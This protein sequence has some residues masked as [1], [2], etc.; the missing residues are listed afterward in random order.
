AHPDRLRSRG[1]PAPA[2]FLPGPSLALPG[3]HRGARAR[4]ARGRRPA[5]LPAAV[6]RGGRR[7]RRGGTGA[8]KSAVILGCDGQDGRLLSAHLKGKGYRTLGI[9]RGTARADGIDWSRPVDITRAD[10]VE[11]LVSTVRPDAI[12][13]LA[14]IHHSSEEAPAE[15]LASM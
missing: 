4:L 15:D 6:H 10:E 1:P 8:M 11:A 14:A 13:H 3:R 12:C 5:G 9:G 7:F 2:R